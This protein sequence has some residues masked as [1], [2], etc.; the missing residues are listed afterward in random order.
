MAAAAAAAVFGYPMPTHADD[1][2]VH[3]ASV[4]LPPPIPCHFVT[5][6]TCGSFWWI[7]E[8]EMASVPYS[9][10]ASAKGKKKDDSI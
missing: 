4:S 7:P 6:L 5:P 8:V 1:L 9:L 10:S 2:S 3:L